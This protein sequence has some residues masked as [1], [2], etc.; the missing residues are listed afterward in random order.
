M[1]KFGGH[2]S[3]EGGREC[4]ISFL[5]LKHRSNIPIRQGRM[6]LYVLFI[7]R[8]NH[9]R[10]NRKVEVIMLTQNQR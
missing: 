9:I 6:L 8:Q 3:V 10:I 1:E 5:N 7:Q 4:H 2:D